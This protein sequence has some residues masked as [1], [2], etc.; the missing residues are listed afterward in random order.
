MRSYLLVL[1]QFAAILAILLTGPLWA[2]APWLLA[3]ELA[4]L[5]LV[6]WA[7]LAMQLANLHVLPD[8][9]SNAQ[10][11]Q[12]GPYRWIRHPMYSAILLATLALVIDAFTWLRL[13]FW[14]VLLIDLLIKLH[15]EERLLAA[16]YTDYGYYQQQTKRL[17]PFVY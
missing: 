14:F 16:H 3:V 10:L 4:G 2:R 5:A 17:L 11:V 6:L 12:R 13:G 1:L 9:R 8:V 7:L 15:Y